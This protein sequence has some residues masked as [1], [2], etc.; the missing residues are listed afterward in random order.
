MNFQ[1]ID[2]KRLYK[3]VVEQLENYI[4]ANQLQPGD[5]LPTERELAEQLNISRGTVREAFRVLEANQIIESRSGSGRFLGQNFIIANERMD[6]ISQLENADL[7]DLMELREIV[8]EK[9]LELTIDKATDEDILLIQN[10]LSLSND[11]FQND[12]AFHLALAEVSGNNALFNVLKFNLNLMA[13]IRRA[14]LRNPGRSDSM[15]HE[16]DIILEA[17]I[18][19]NKKRAKQ[20]LMEHLKSI[21][22]S[23]ISEQNS[24]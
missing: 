24:K 18:A 19:R 1:K 22:Q 10:A 11:P 2:H 21:R 12:N 17:I 23:I 20:A 7:L 15:R 3:D 8:E 16:H 4:I 5:K 13:Q 6:I 9:A 14:S